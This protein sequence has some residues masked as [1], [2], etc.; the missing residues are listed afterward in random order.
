MI[1]LSF[2]CQF[3]FNVLAGPVLPFGEVANDMILQP[4]C[5]QYSDQISLS[6]PFVYFGRPLS[7][8]YINSNGYL[9][10]EEIFTY[11]CQTYF[12]T[13]SPPLIAI[14]WRG[15]N[16]SRFGR[17]DSVTYRLTRDPETLVNIST[18]ITNTYVPFTPSYA[19]IVTWYMVPSDNISDSSLYTFQAILASNGSVSFVA[20]AYGNLDGLQNVQVGFNLGDGYTYDQI[21]SNRFL[22]T[23]SVDIHTG[24][25]IEETGVY[26]FRVDS[27]CAE[28]LSD[29][30]EYS[31]HF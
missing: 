11:C 6:P 10:F 26:L 28:C 20:F 30:Y 27:K 19:V 9:S 25:N 22:Y 12:P 2:H 1:L 23:S 8:L 18:F 5:N 17:E 21:I 13:R 24:S 31:L 7:T 4:G 15:Y 16:T 3:V 14:L 29:Y